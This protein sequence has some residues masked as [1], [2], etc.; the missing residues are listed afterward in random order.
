[1]K[2]SIV[3]PVF[4]EASNIPPLYAALVPQLESVSMDYEILFVDDGST[5]GSVEEIRKLRARTDRVRLLSL[6]RN[7]GHQIALTAGIDHAS[8]D[9]IVLMDADLQHPPA[10]IPQLISRWLDG[11]EVVHTIRKTTAESS[12]PKRATAAAF[13]RV[14]RLLSRVDLPSNA[15]D[16]RLIDRK[17]ADALRGIRE[18]T[19]FLRGLT[20]WAGYRSTSISYDAPTRQAGETKYSPARMLK[21]AID[22]LV[23]FSAAPLHLAVYAG[24]VL[25]LL[26][27][28]YAG[29]ALYARFV[30]GHVLPGWTSL[31]IL[32]SIVGGIQLVLMGVIGVYLGKIFEEVKRRPLYLVRSRLGIDVPRFESQEPAP[33]ADDGV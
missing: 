20:V 24:I 30:T 27:F 25:A 23:S 9:A 29:Y 5:D 8:G 19:R 21:L 26:G 15:A 4:N 16:F 17:V 10:L 6:S 2:I 14:F 11:F 12:W 13:Y 3:I 32:V 18:R 31:A 1:M 7:F 22:A 28:L 33:V